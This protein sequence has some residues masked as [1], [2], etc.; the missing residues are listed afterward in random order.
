MKTGIID[1]GGGQRGIFACGVFDRLMDEGICFDLGI[2]VSAGSANISSYIA[3]QRGRNLQFYL[4]YVQREEYLSR[5]NLREKGCMLDVQYIYGTLSNSDGENPLDYAAFVKNPMDFLVVATEAKT[6]QA[7]YLGKQ[8]MRPDYYNA[9]MASSAIP[10]VC[11]PQRVDDTVY[12]DGS[13]SDPIPLERAF[14]FGCEK[15]VLLLNCPVNDWDSSKEDKKLAK[16]IEAKYPRAAQALCQ[17]TEKYNE[18]V[19]YARRA[20]SEGRVLILAPQQ[21]HGVG[22]LCKDISNLWL[23]YEDGYQA[24]AEICSYLDTK[25]K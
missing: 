1:V 10:Y 3:G 22:T 25:P 14:S 15:V 6:G 24:G 7:A 5:N 19:E 20:A 11:A 4:K 2:G 17:R 8:T 23:L 21:L 12:F 9:L 18:G 13:I 16:H